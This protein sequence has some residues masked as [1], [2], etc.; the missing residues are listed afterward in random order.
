[1]ND[2]HEI[3]GAESLLNE[4]ARRRFDSRRGLQL[5]VQVVE[6]H[7]VDPA[8][9]RP[10]VRLHV[11]LDGLRSKERAIGSLDRDI[12]QR[13]GADGL[14]LPVLEHLEVFLLQI[15]D[16]P[17]LLVRHE[18]VDFDV[19]DLELEGR[20]LGSLRGSRRLTRRRLSG[21]QRRPRQEENEPEQARTSS[22][23]VLSLAPETFRALKQA[24]TRLRKLYRLSVAAPWL[25]RIIGR[26]GRS[27]SRA[28][29]GAHR[30]QP[31][32]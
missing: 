18:R 31:Y 24:G 25:R 13:E 14:R 11:G 1:M 32:T 28:D 21:R 5:H 29:P 15:A 16:E 19:V 23:A 2:G 10:R 17:A 7:D 8:V 6:Q 4:P 9:E 20:R 30:N 22:H 26:L 12:D 27:A 3:V